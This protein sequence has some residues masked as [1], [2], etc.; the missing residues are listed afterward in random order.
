VKLSTM[1]SY[2]GDIVVG[3]DEI[4]ALEAA[5]LDNVWVPEAYSF[6][7]VSMMGYLAARTARVEIG[8][9]IVNVYTRTPTLLAM[10]FAGLDAVSGGRV[11]CGLGA[12]GPQVIEGFHGVPYE[13]PMQRIRETIEV[14]RATWQREVIDF[15]GQTIDIPLP[16][17]QGTGLGRALKL[18]NHP[19]RPSIPIWWASLKGRSVEATAEMA[20]GWIPAFFVPERAERVWGTSLAAGGQ[21]RLPGLGPLQ[22]LAG[23]PVRITDDVGVV[24]RVLDGMR[25]SIALYAGGMGAR[26]KNFY[27]DVM[28]ASGW[29]AEAKRVQDLYLE[30]HQEAAAAE[31]PADYL[32]AMALVG[33]RGRVR[34]RLAAYREAGVTHLQMGLS[35]TLD[36]KIATVASMRELVDEL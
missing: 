16:T 18:I 9:A 32:S 31:L 23:G 15:H 28:A 5:G 13:A 17:G 1:L 21:K 25:P 11:N 30:G 24:A 36:D 7:A 10:T 33:P 8:S 2:A 14:C 29:E 19:I 22:V 20:D 12:S 6:D 3:A 26:G 35:G 27:N 4:S 34:E